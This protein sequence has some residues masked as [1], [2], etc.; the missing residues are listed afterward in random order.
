MAIFPIA[1]GKGAIGA[2]SS[3]AVNFIAI[4]NGRIGVPARAIAYYRLG[5]ML[6][7]ASAGFGF[8]TSMGESSGPAGAVV[9]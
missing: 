4:S 5:S 8:V 1:I 2:W 7:V 9:P 6:R 3:S